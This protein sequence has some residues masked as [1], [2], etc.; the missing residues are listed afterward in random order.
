MVRAIVLLAWILVALPVAASEVS[1]GPAYD[2]PLAGPSRSKGAVIY[3]HGKNVGADPR[4]WVPPYIDSVRKAG[5]DVYKLVRPVGADNVNDSADAL[6][7]AAKELRAM[8]YARV[9]TMG[10]SYGAWISFVAAGRDKSL[11][12]AIVATA[13]AAYGYSGQNTRYGDFNWQDNAQVVSL[14]EEIGRSRVM[15]FFFRLD[16]FDPGGRGARMQAVLAE[17]K[18]MYAVFDQP[19]GY[20]GHSAALS[21]RFAREFGD[22]IAD[23]LNAQEAA[24]PYACPPLSPRDH[25]SF[26]ELPGDLAIE[27]PSPALPNGHKAFAG[28]WLGLY[29]NGREMVLAVEKIS[30]A[31]VAAVYAWTGLPGSD[32]AG[33]WVR[34]TGRIDGSTLV[35]TNPKRTISFTPTPEG[36]LKVEWTG[37]DGRV[38]K[39]VASR[40]D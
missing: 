37:S 36:T 12:D 14:A 25:L 35:F 5:W 20:T 33:G 23:F 22:C 39:T 7:A 21:G 1:F 26:F 15:A 13:P 38:L 8:G 27:P 4:G 31:E 10:Q 9:A 16:D 2:T 40:I 19:A 34:L 3:N 32:E 30:Q 28:K 6:I 17:R 29:D 18:L 24:G 11:F